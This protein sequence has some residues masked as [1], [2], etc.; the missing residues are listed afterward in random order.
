MTHAPRALALLARDGAA[1]RGAFDA[2]GP[3]A[4][5]ASN[6]DAGLDAL[7]L[8]WALFAARATATV[9]PRRPGAGAPRPGAASGRAG[10]E[11][12]ARRRLPGARPGDRLPQDRRRRERTRRRDE[13]VLEERR[14]AVRQSG[15]ALYPEPF[16]WGAYADAAP[17]R[18]V[19]VTRTSVWM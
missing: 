16:W 11:L 8:L 14:A 2:L 1:F 6:P 3:R 9:A 15:G 17:P 19:E 5:N 12:A 18:F 4:L 13:Y 7:C 10:V